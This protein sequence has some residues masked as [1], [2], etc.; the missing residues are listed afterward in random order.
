QLRVD[1]AEETIVDQLGVPVADLLES[2]A[3]GE[4]F[5]RAEAEARL[6]QAEKDL[7]VLG[8]V[9]PLALEEFKAMEERHDFL[10]TQLDDVRRARKDLLD[11]V[12]DVDET[13]LRLFTEA[14]L[15]VEREFPKVFDTL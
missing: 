13:I 8:R 10:A 6:K 5:D 15:D 2:H 12:D 1:Q 4:D 3:P 14:W 7:R 11:V 9:N